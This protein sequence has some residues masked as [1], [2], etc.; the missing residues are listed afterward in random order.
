MAFW[1]G[2]LGF[3]ENGRLLNQGPTQWRLDGLDGALVDIVT[4]ETAEGG[5]HVELL[6]YRGPI[7]AQPARRFGPQDI[8]ATRLGIRCTPSLTNKKGLEA[9]EVQSEVDEGLV[10]SDPNGHLVELST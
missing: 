1:V 3:R 7:T 9:F 4:L 2:R 8:P 10:L 6:H 5:I